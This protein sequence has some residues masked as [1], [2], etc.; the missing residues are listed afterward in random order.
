MVRPCTLIVHAV[1]AYGLVHSAPTVARTLTQDSAKKK[2][3]GPT[4]K[5]RRARSTVPGIEP[6]PWKKRLPTAKIPAMR[7]LAPKRVW[8]PEP[9]TPNNL[10]AAQ[11]ARALKSLCVSIPKK[12][13]EAYG[14]WILQYAEA[15]AVDPMLVAAYIYRQSRCRADGW[16][17]R[18]KD[19]RQDYGIGLGRIS[20]KVHRP[21][22]KN[23]TYGFW[24]F[25]DSA[26]KKQEEP[27]KDFPFTATQ[28]K[29]PQANIYFT[30]ALASIYQKQ[31]KSLDLAHKSRPHRH[32]ISHLVWGDRVRGGRQEDMVLQARRRLLHYYSEKEP[33]ARLRS[34]KLAIYSPLDGAP[35]KVSSPFGQRR[36]RRRRHV[37]HRGMDYVS[38][39]GEPIRVVADGKVI[40]AGVQKLRSRGA[41]ILSPEAAR[42]L[43]NRKMGRGGLFLIIEHSR[44]FRSAYFHVSSYS[45]KRGDTV[46]GGQIIARVGRT[47]I[48]R[49]PAHL[50]LEFRRNRRKV[51]PANYLHPYLLPPP[52]KKLAKKARKRKKARMAKK[53]PM[54]KAKRKGR[55]KRPYVSASKK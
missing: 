35:R 43:P 39:W 47:G 34:G 51:N 1:L 30:T 13:A 44:G 16:I 50:H 20:H 22:V 26:W 49:S 28:L 31:C 4:G 3:T 48:K 41:R 38:T 11:F 21:L 2:K 18:K 17:Q 29:K 8:P 14:K 25:E 46:K 19:D 40:F 36:I 12:N 24:T 27:I 54:R 55:S 32:W 33:V 45:V 42:R 23:G 5:K 53:R 10:D 9:A 15:F 6:I 52:A 7:S 37:R